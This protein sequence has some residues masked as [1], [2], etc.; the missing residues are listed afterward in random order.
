MGVERGFERKQAVV[1][2]GDVLSFVA[3]WSSVHV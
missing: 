2:A 3:V 1:G